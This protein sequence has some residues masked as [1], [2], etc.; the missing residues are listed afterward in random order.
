MVSLLGVWRAHGIDEILREAWEAGVDP[1]RPLGRLALLVRRGGDRLPRRA[2]AARGARPAAVQQLR[3]LRAG[4]KRRRAYHR[5][6]REGMRPGYAAEDGAALHFT[7]G[8]EPGRRLA[9]GGS[10]LPARRRRRS[11]WSRCGSPPPSSATRGRAGGAACPRRSRPRL[12]GLSADDGPPHPR[13][14]RPRLHLAPARP[15]G[16]RAAAAAGD[17][18]R[19]RRPRICILPTAS[20]DTSDQIGRFYAAFGERACEPS[21][22]SL[23]R[24]GRRPMALRDHLLAQDLI[25]VGGGSLVNLL[26][27]WEAHDLG[28][29]SASPGARASSS[30]AR[31]P[32]RC[33]GSRPGSPNRRAGPLPGAGLGLLERQP[34]RPLQ[35]R[36]RA[37]RRLPRRGRQRDAGRL[38]PRRLRRPA[39]GGQR[40]PLGPDRPPRRPRLPRQSGETGVTESPLP[41]RF[42]PAPAPAALRED[43]AE[44]RRIKQMRHARRLAGLI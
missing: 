8:T 9:P 18:A 10:R 15:R 11:G 20:G 25:Y 3:P 33:A 37:P 27:V 39:L 43:I 2:A 44:F 41:A 17:R 38:R 4:S 40:H 35:Q 19:R 1:L 22:L 12:G 24:L 34:L 14:R 16:L 26:A 7:G 23:F 36:A 21:D 13:P 29:S 28:G 32:A 42:L 5:F 31:A 30:P 6:L